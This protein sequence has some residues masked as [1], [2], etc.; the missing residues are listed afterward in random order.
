[1]TG[2]IFSLAFFILLLS[3]RVSSAQPDFAV[4][5]RGI[6]LTIS[7]QYDSALHVFNALINQEPE[8]PA[9]YFLTAALWQSKMMDFETGQWE[10]EFYH[11]IDKAI[12]LA[13]L[14]LEKNPADAFAHFYLGGAMSY[15]SFQLARNKKYIPA[16]SMALKSISSLNK[17]IELDSTI[18]DSYLGVGSY[19]YWRS[20]I[21][22]KI[23]WLPFF[24]DQRK[25]G[26]AD[27]LQAR[28]CGRFSK[29]AA[30]SN[31]AWIYIEE[32]EYE[33][34]L[35]I[36]RDGLNK[37]PG[38]RFFMWPLGEAQLKSEKWPEAIVTYNNLLVS[39][40]K[41]TINNHYNEIVIYL[42]LAKCYR[43][44]HK[45]EQAFNACQ[46]VINIEPAAEVMDRA[47]EKKQEA[48]KLLS[49]INRENQ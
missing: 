30:L 45:N 29:W 26:I 21:T 25:E 27:L 16:I 17:T 8:H 10:N 1:M 47:K 37:F 35:Q 33:K 14:Y 11:N 40:Q 5:N 31:L 12:A 22:Q 28:D 3:G 18:C 9:G 42:K 43:A 38:S 41:E 24:S 49:E 39:V 36:S 32:K 6:E 48:I 7:E 23:A 34:A 15:K 20:K 46:Q 2:R 4:I 13:K 19:L 44:S